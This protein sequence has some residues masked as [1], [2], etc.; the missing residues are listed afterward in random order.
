MEVILCPLRKSSWAGVYK[1]K[2]CSD[3]I[4]TYLT[5]SGAIHTGLT[6]E[7]AKRLGE[8]LGKDLHPSSE[9][10]LDFYIRVGGKDVFLHLDD[11]W[12]EL[13]Y[14]YLKSHK[15]VANGY[16]DKNPYADYVLVN[17]EVE[18]V[19]SNKINQIKRKAMKEF[20]KLSLTDMRK[21]LRLYGVKSDNLTSELVESKLFDIVERDP[22]KFF[23]KWVNNS[24]RETDY[25]I[26]EA[27]AKN[28][29]RRNKSEYKYGTDSIG[30]TLDDT[31]S[32]LDS[33]ENRD[34][35]AIIINEVNT[36]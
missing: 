27:V 33:P 21:I 19:E 11:P 36:K 22:N 9:F 16:I 12:D 34:L 1:Y 20:D 6:E 8:K 28:V 24:K 2:N 18:A 14:L 30:H 17:K 25:L 35:K 32:Y 5:R 15:R 23:D 4:G 26:Q 13:R 7:D 29:I 3:Y 10:W 31:I